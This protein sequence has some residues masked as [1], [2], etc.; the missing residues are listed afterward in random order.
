MAKFSKQ[1]NQIELAE[2][3]RPGQWRSGPGFDPRKNWRE[4]PI[5]AALG[6]LGRRV[7]EVIR[8]DIFSK[9]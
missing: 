7:L 8:A 4:V 6:Q 3:K 1:L 5:T 2:M 9:F